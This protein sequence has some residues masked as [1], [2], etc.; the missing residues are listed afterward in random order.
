[1]TLKTASMNSIGSSRGCRINAWTYR[2]KD[3]I[4]NEVTRV[5]KCS[6]NNKFLLKANCLIKFKT[7][8]CPFKRFRYTLYFKIQVVI[9]YTF[10]Q[11][12]TCIVFTSIRNSPL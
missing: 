8:D 12:V 1:M 11:K 7:I 3:L 4:V 9:G 2:S 6:L 10:F 5:P